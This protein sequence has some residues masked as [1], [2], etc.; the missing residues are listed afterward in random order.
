MF[1]GLPT[2]ACWHWSESSGKGT[3]ERQTRPF[4]RRKAG[5]HKDEYQ[6][7]GGHHSR[8]DT[9]VGR[10]GDHRFG[11]R[12]SVPTGGRRSVFKR[13][14]SEP[15]IKARM[16]A[17]SGFFWCSGCRICSTVPQKDDE[18]T[19]RTDTNSD[20]TPI[21]VGQPRKRISNAPMRWNNHATP[22]ALQ[23]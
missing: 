5:Q 6:E 11:N 12:S 4:A 7:Q 17:P 9:R 15:K 8:L 14:T 2:A 3:G 16:L 10:S 13:P 20:Q 21:G 18:S 22:E 1:S 23:T 19:W